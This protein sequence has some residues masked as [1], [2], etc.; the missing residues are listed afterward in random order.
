MIYPAG[1]Y[2]GL[3]LQWEMPCSRLTAWRWEE[4]RMP[5]IFADLYLTFQSTWLKHIVKSKYCTQAIIKDIGDNVGPPIVV[6]NDGVS[7]LH[8]RKKIGMQFSVQTDLWSKTKTVL[9]QNAN[10][11]HALC[12]LQ[13]HFRHIRNQRIQK[14]WQITRRSMTRVWSP[15]TLFYQWLW[16]LQHFLHTDFLRFWYI[17]AEP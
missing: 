13:V 3:I 10:A 6:T 9:M 11:K 12:L 8:M 16:F 7:L 15:F 1:A 4:E 2:R 17:W 5:Q 14:V